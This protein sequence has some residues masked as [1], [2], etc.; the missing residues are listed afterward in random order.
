VKGYC[1]LSEEERGRRRG[2]RRRRRRRRGRRN[3]SSLGAAFGLQRVVP[4][5]VVVVKAELNLLIL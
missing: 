2:R 1:A 4:W 3:F 5:V